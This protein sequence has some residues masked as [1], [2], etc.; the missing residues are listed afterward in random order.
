MLRPKQEMRFEDSRVLRWRIDEARLE[1]DVQIRFLGQRFSHAIASRNGGTSELGS[2]IVVEGDQEH[3][4][5]FS[6]L[7]GKTSNRVSANVEEA[8]LRFIGSTS[9]ALVTG[10][11]VVFERLNA[12]GSAQF[13]ILKRVY[14]RR[15]LRLPFGYLQIAP[16]TLIDEGRR[17]LTWISASRI[18]GI[19]LPFVLGGHYLHRVRLWLFSA[20]GNGSPRFTKDGLTLE[21]D[22]FEYQ[23]ARAQAVLLRLR[24]TKA[25]GY[26]ADSDLNELT[27]PYLIYRDLT[28]K[29][30]QAILVRHISAWLQSL[31][32]DLGIDVKIDMSGMTSPQEFIEMR[33]DVLSGRK[34]FSEALNLR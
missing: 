34:T 23:I 24:G 7:I 28:F 20:A 8:L 32:K 2:G 6:V 21:L 15:A 11:D 31:C 13:S 5:R 22:G 18:C 10:E 9:A 17:R 29:W 4:E 14:I 33:G 30:A 19:A 25:I 16:R 3:I 12:V 27:E 26:L 1:R